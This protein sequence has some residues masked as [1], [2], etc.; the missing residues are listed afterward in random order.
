MAVEGYYTSDMDKIG[1]RGRSSLMKSGG[2]AALTI[3]QAAR[4]FTTTVAPNL[5][6]TEKVSSQGPGASVERAMKAKE[7]LRDLV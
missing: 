6:R 3:Q 1:A 4:K 2:S 5:Q 7:R